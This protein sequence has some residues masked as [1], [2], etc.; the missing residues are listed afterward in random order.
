MEKCLYMT[1][2]AKASANRRKPLYDHSK[3]EK[4]W[5]KAWQDQATYKTDKPGK[6]KKMY[7]LDMFPYPSGAGLHVGHPRGYIG[8]DV[9]A[10]MKRMCG[11]N[12]LHP[13][14]YDAFGLPAEQYAIKHKVHPR[15]AV[16]KNVATFEKQLSIMGLSYDWSR[17]VNTTDP[18]YYKWTQWIF[19]KLYDAWYDPKK[20]KARDISELIA[21]F[22]KSGGST[23]SA[24]EWKS[25]SHLEK[26]EVLM[27]YRLAYEGYADVNWSPSMATV[28]ANDEVVIKADGSMVSERDE[29]P[30]IKKTLRQ[31][32]MR[33]T[34]YA[35]RLAA[36]LDGINWP[37]NIKEIQKNWI[38]KSQG[39]EI[40]FEIVAN[41][42][43]V[44][45]IAVFTTRPDTLF[46]V[47]YV[48]FAPEHQNVQ[49]LKEYITNW[50][51]VERY[52][53][54]VTNKDEIER[55]N[56][57]KVKTG[58]QLK[59]LFAINPANGEKVPVWIADYVLAAYGTGAVMAV[60]AHD[61]RDFLFAKKYK[62]PIR[63]VVRPYVIDKINTPVPDKEFIVRTN[64]HAIVFDPKTKKYLIL[65]NKKFNW[66]TVIIGGVEEGEDFIEA[67]MREIREE[68]GYQNVKFKR[69]LGFPVQAAYFAKHKDQN[70]MAIATALYFEIVDHEQVDVS[71]DAEN[72][73]NEIIWVTKEELVPGKMV[74]SELPY[75]L[76]RLEEKEESAYLGDG[77]LVNSDD[78]NGLSSEEAKKAITVFVKGTLVTRY[79]MRDAIFARQRY[80][81]EPIPLK[82]EVSGLITPLK[83]KQLPLLLP[84]VKSYEPSGTGESPLATV[85][86]WIKEG[87]E[88]NTMP[89]WAG[90]SWYF[91][92][93]MDPSNTKAF[94][95]EKAIDY[96][97]DVDMYVGGAEHATGHLLYSRF[98]HKFLYDMGYVPTKEP[99]KTLKNQGLIGGADG[100]KMSKRWGNVVNPDDVVK[101]YGADSLR[102]F[103]MFLGPFESHLP[104]STDGIIGSR[105]F[106]ER[107]WRLADS[108]FGS[109]SA[110][111]RKVLHKTIKKITDDIENFSFNT[112][113]S[114]LMIC[115]NEFESAAQGSGVT[116]EDFKIFLQLLAPFAPHVAEELWTKFDGKGSIHRSAW[117]TYNA[118]YLIEEDVT[119]GVQVN[120]KV[121]AEL[122]VAT[123][124]TKESVESAALALAR[125]Q[126]YITGKTVKKVIAIPGKIVNIVIE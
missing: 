4:K 1:S 89:G 102:L 33:I 71:T 10:R 7:V 106:I 120:G 112:A 5:Q 115:L 99:F 18:E 21:Q 41:G 11:F 113:V 9:Y 77:V 51:E 84:N 31:W 40:R 96:W 61:Q 126:E 91:L 20:N 73:G 92:R 63:E 75:W 34:A 88:T 76:Q 85:K 67:A 32:F 52:I 123:D 100:R 93:Y 2:S 38:G 64:V 105:R 15:I 116:K 114:Q 124:A 111:T 59:G 3:I 101:T 118:K 65:R 58:V 97:R 83:E 81:G 46:G 82:H 54:E 86:A 60:P 47:T 30:V 87:Y 108:V 22:E 24:K 55:T 37:N 8:S 12:V 109:S 50:P 121:R 119:I 66:D 44:G 79:K 68:T 25:F 16:E 17:K 74:N 57:D 19:L 90:S 49:A 95:G 39:S 28:L 72:D 98:W 14:G 27:H 36:D 26:Q 70:R 103:E 45:D 48:V 6:A 13:M 94:A 29:L 125:I 35:D 56:V 43:G 104:W 107:V 42:H 117:P 110:T 23:F 122:T 53:S 69:A 80:W 62:L 78:F